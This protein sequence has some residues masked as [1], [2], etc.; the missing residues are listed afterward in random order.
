[1][2]FS[3]ILFVVPILA[4]CTKTETTSNDSNIINN[5][6]ARTHHKNEMESRPATRPVRGPML[7]LG[8]DALRD[9]R[10]TTRSV[11]RRQGGESITAV[12]SLAVDPNSIFT[13]APPIGAKI[14]HIQKTVGEP[15][16]KGELLVTLDAPE[17]ARAKSAIDAARR[18]MQ[19][20]N[21]K[22]TVSV[23][24][25]DAIAGLMQQKM[26]TIKDMQSA[27][28]EVASRKADAA[29]AEQDLAHAEMLL[30]IYQITTEADGRTFQLKSAES[31]FVYFRD[32]STGEAVEAGHAIFKIIQPRRLLAVVHPFERDAL[33]IDIQQKARIT[34]SAFP[35][36]SFDATFLRL[37]PEVN[38]S[39]RTLPARFIVENDLYTLMPGM[40]VQAEIRLASAA[41]AEIVSIPIGALQRIETAWC[42]FVPIGEGRFERRE[43]VRGRD[44]GAEVEIL[45]GIDPGEK[46]VVEGAFVL[47]SESVRG[48]DLGDEHDH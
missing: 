39:T 16:A 10:L 36:R 4:S 25:R 18:R 32:G 20:M 47:R 45:S 14:V 46:I 11:E 31:G 17:L 3:S 5:P 24:Q 43:V 37:G 12:G 7:Q 48:V 33:R 40:T 22:L 35:G 6:Q 28:S 2:R 27:E 21:E 30:S 26:S 13:I 19:T 34:A 41:T 8:E 38:P 44:L 15:V 9:L 42:V 1:M 23:S 29:E